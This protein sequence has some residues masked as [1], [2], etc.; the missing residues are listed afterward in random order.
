RHTVVRAPLPAP[1]VA[2][3]EL[4]HRSNLA[5]SLPSHQLKDDWPPRRHQARIAGIDLIRQA[6][7]ELGIMATDASAGLGVLELPELPAELPEVQA[8]S[9]GD[10][11]AGHRIVGQ[12]AV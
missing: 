4:D 1:S 2:F 11:S 3:V 12:P 9:L 7:V 8:S 10:R 5:A 6:L